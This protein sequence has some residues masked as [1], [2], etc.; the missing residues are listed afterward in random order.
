MMSCLIFQIFDPDTN[1]SDGGS[2]IPDWRNILDDFDF[3]WMDGL[4]FDPIAQSF[5]VPSDVGA[6]IFAHSVDLYFKTKGTNRDVNVEIR[7]MLNGYPTN[8]AIALSKVL[9]HLQV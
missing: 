6:G 3:S 8:E 5:Q 1:T 2:T 4:Y 9:L 7:P